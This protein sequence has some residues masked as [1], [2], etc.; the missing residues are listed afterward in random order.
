MTRP[1]Q[2]G[3][4]CATQL[5]EEPGNEQRSQERRAPLAQDPSEAAVM[6]T[7]HGHGDVHPSVAADHHLGHVSQVGASC[8]AAAA[9]VSSSGAVSPP[10]TRASGS[11]SA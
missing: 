9:V 5:V 8:A 1:H 11:R 10:N 6:Q 3:R 7:F 2:P 4:S